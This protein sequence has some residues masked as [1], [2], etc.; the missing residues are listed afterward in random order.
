MKFVVGED[1][2]GPFDPANASV[3]DKLLTGLVETPPIT[4]TREGNLTMLH[5]RSYCLHSM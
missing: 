5:T 3:D 1:D 2:P 4:R